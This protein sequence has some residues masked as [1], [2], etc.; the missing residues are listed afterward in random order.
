MLVLV[1]LKF[2]LKQHKNIMFQMVV[3]LKKITVG[4]MLSHSEAS[5]EFRVGII[6]CFRMM[7]L[8]LQPCFVSSCSCKQRVIMPASKSIDGAFVPHITILRNHVESLEC[9]LAFLQSQNASAAIGHWLS[10]LLQVS[11]TCFVLC[12]LF[13]YCIVLVI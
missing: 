2:E 12:I 10:L 11:R 7:L 3:V 5:E 6:R 13:Y 1:P 9:L 8:D 4:A